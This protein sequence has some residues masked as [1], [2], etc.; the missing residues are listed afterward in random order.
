MNNIKFS[1]LNISNHIL[2]SL[3]KMGFASATPVQAA[4]IAPIMKKRDVIVQS[5]TGSGKTCAFG[6]PIIE[7]LDMKDDA[8][9]A[10]ILSPTRELAIQTA[11]VLKQLLQ[12]SSGIKVATIY[13][14]EQYGIQLKELR[15]KPKIIVATPGRMMDFLQRGAVKLDRLKM[16][17]LDEADRMLEMGFREELDAIFDAMPQ[18]RQTVMFSATMSKEVKKIALKFQKNAHMI[19]IKQ[20]EETVGNIEQHYITIKGKTKLPVLMHLLKENRKSTTLVFVGTKKM[21]DIVAAQLQEKGIRAAALHGDLR[22]RQRDAVMRKY[23]QKSINVLVATD[24]AAR[25]IDVNDIG[26][27]IN[28]DIPQNSDDYVHRIGRTGR[29]MKSG[30]AYTFIYTKERQRLN[31]IIRETGQQIKPLIIT[32]P[33]ES[34]IRQEYISTPKAPRL[35][36]VPRAKSV[37]DRAKKESRVDEK[38]YTRLFVSIGVMDKINRKS[39]AELVSDSGK[40]PQRL[41]GAVSVH[42]AYS[43][44]DVPASYEK[45]V[46]DGLTGIEIDGRTVK[47]EPKNG[48][49][50]KSVRPA[51]MGR[52]KSAEKAKAGSRSKAASRTSAKKPY[53][54]RPGRHKQ[55]LDVKQP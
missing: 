49:K 51:D 31:E 37:S 55:T 3:D 26:A 13:G 22:Q 24:V 5:P 30:V 6:I 33:A 28:F 10:L 8:V 35:K 23:R 42:G 7:N 25:G 19:Q 4:S 9:Q 29:A 16:A 20:S 46:I 40:L 38:G 27:V 17:V 36:E 18:S 44:V 12:F 50:K 34:D 52:K 32:V 41:I 21:A 45:A 1:E 2:R 39:L 43:F 53:V 15:R 48:I 47:V 11:V 14:G 54:K